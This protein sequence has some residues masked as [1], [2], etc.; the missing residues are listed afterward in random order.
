VLHEEENPMCDD[1]NK[2]TLLVRREI[3]AGIAV[4]LIKAFMEEIGRKE[5]LEIVRKVI[6]ELAAESGRMLAKMVDGNSLEHLT[7]A[8][9]VFAQGGALE[10][11]IVESSPDRLALNTTRCRFADIC[12]EHGW[13]EI[14]YLLSCGRDYAMIKGFN[15]K[16]KL[17]RTQTVMEGAPFCDFRFEM[18]D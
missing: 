17:T 9:A 5:A 7:K 12:K 10:S 16:I 1:V 15:P 4:P 2:V 3:E 8:A 13:E 14:G 18:T 11:E 6:E